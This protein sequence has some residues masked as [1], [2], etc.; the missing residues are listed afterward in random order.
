MN[1]F[2]DHEQKFLAL[3]Q[4]VVIN[5]KAHHIFWK[6]TE[7]PSTLKDYSDLYTKTDPDLKM[8]WRNDV[9]FAKQ[10]LKNQ[11]FFN[12]SESDGGQSNKNRTTQQREIP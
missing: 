4:A 8:E 7:L 12:I 1:D 11:Q 10:V 2:V 9:E 3:L 5:I 6:K